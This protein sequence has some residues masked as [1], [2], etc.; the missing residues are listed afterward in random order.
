[1]TLANIN[2]WFECDTFPIALKVGSV[3]TILKKGDPIDCSNYHPVSLT[4]NLSKLLE[5]LIRNRIYDFLEKHI[6]LL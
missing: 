2:L 5:K 6:F 3:T 1:M 4:S